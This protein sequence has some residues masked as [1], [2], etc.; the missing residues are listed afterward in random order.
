MRRS[1]MP[2]AVLTM[3]SCWEYLLARQNTYG[4]IVGA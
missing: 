4:Q 1:V 2:A 3:G